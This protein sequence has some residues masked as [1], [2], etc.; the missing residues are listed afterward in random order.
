M[1]RGVNIPSWAEPVLIADAIDPTH[2]GIVHAR[3]IHRDASIDYFHSIGGAQFH[4]RSQV[5]YA[6]TALDT[7]VYHAHL[8]DFAPADR[9]SI[10]VDVGGGDGRN[11]LAWLAWGF[12]RVIIVDPIAASLLRLQ[13]RMAAEHPDWL[14]RILLMEANARDLPL[15]AGVASRVFAIESLCYLNE[16]YG[17]GVEECRR[18]L[19]PDGRLLISDRDYEGGLLAELLYGGGVEG[20]LK[21]GT[22]PDLADGPGGRRAR[23]RCF[24]RGQLI[25]AIERHGLK[26]VATSG[27]SGLSLLLGYLRGTGQL[28]DNAASRI[29]EVHELLARLGRNGSFLRAHVVVAEHVRNQG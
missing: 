7:P 27:I 8:K 11:T 5:A 14:D 12:R 26:V 9:N 2:D 19:A 21:P 20:L 15:R 10:V 29:D 17:A 22:G 3:S 16:D 24:T 1:S 13:G 6:M 18:V 25:A 4:E 23:S 28:G